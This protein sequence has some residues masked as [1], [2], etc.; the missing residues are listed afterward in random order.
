M[1]ASIL[2]RVLSIVAVYFSSSSILLRTSSGDR[3][4]TVSSVMVFIMGYDVWRMRYLHEA[5]G[6]HGFTFTTA[7]PGIVLL[8][9][10]G[11]WICRAI[12]S[13]KVGSIYDIDKKL[14][15]HLWANR[16]VLHIMLQCSESR[17]LV[18]LNCIRL[19]HNI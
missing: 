10:V 3:C 7:N 16:T 6:T 5:T 11:G 15:Y 12:H 14:V 2:L 17:Y 13:L 4:L 18:V 8:L 9:H 19:S 1:A